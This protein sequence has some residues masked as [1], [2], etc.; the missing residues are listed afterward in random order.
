VE[1][2]V[3][4][5]WG[6]ENCRIILSHLADAMIP[7]SRVLITEQFMSD[8]PVN[9]TAWN[10]LLMFN[11]G[12]KERTVENWRKLTSAAGLQAVKFW[13]TP[14]EVIGVIECVKA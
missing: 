9:F 2:R 13:T 10:D 5:D 4:H 3:L 6:D 11:I 7:E 14:G 8:P 12:G 1:R